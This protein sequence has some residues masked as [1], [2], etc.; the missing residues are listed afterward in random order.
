MD[1]WARDKLFLWW[2]TFFSVDGANRIQ[3]PKVESSNCKN[4]TTILEY[5][6]Q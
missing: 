6:F 4:E 2:Y 1:D 3:K 5:H